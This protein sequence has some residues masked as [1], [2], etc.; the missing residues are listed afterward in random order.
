M[1]TPLLMLVLTS[2]MLGGTGAIA[3]SGHVMLRPDEIT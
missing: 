3:Q 2:F 1:R